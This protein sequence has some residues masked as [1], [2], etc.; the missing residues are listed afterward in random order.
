MSTRNKTMKIINYKEIMTIETIKR[1]HNV[2]D[3]I[4][5]GNNDLALAELTKI[6]NEQYAII[7]SDIVLNNKV[8][9]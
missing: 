5:L 1:L 2:L 6:L 3:D 4:M 8:K 7:D 9:R